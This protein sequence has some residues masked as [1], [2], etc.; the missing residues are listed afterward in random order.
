MA[1]PV[2]ELKNVTK[3]Y[4]QGQVDIHALGGV[5]LQIEKGEFTALCGP[6]GSG[7]TT[8][9]NII[10]ALDTP[11]AGSVRLEDV[12]LSGLRM[13]SKSFWNGP[14]ERQCGKSS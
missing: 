3:D 2:I 4:R 9:L 14:G 6:S 13:D 11:T 8:V 5:D 10:G 7:K 12:D 1:K